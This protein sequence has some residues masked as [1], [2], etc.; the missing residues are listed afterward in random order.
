MA[1]DQ[2]RHYEMAGAGHATADELYY[3]AAP[4]DIIKAGRTVPPMAC[5]E[6]PRIRFPSWTFFDAS[7]RNLELWVREGVAPRRAEPIL[8]RDGALVLDQFGNVQGGLRSSYLDVPV[9]TWFGTSTGASFC[10]IAG[11]EQRWEKSTL[12]ALYPD[13][14][15]YVQQVRQDVRQRQDGRFLT[16]AEGRWL[17][18]EA[19]QAAVPR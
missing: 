4:A 14:G 10:F 1:P 6:G 19:A 15:A 12:Q 7:L 17:V 8:V 13:H 11:H 16:A 3:S 2:Y 18:R 5:N 9:S